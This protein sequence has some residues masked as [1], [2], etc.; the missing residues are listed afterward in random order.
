M[1]KQL[2][3]SDILPVPEF[4]GG[5]V[6]TEQANELS[7]AVHALQRV[8]VF[9][10]QEITRLNQQVKDLAATPAKATTATSK[11]AAKK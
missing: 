10:H 3:E 7:R 6:S 9:Q 11:T 4:I 2:T 5:E 8:T 1:T